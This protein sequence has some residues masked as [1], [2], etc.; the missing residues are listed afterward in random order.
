VDRTSAFY[1][2]K[3]ARYY[4]HDARGVE[5]GDPKA[6]ADAT[7]TDPAATK[8]EEAKGKKERRSYVDRQTR[9]RHDLFDERAQAPKSPRELHAAYG[10]DIR[11]ATQPP[12]EGPAPRYEM[13]FPL[14]SIQHTLLLC[15]FSCFSTCRLKT[16]RF[17]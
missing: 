3:D 13:P 2:P 12:H 14:V 16:E 11:R 17:C 10:Y 9:W 1:V 15:T 5:N 4:E 8:A 6:E 7:G